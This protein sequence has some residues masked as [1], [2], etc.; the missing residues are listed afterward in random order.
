MEGLNKFKI[1]TVVFI[2]MFIFVVAAI[3]SNTKDASAT[4]N[5][6]KAND[7][8][9]IKKE[10]INDSNISIDN[11]VIEE[12]Y[13]KVEHLSKRV[14]EVAA[15]SSSN[16]ADMKCSIRGIMNNDEIEELSAETALQE[17]R[18]NDSELVMTCRF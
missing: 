4:K 3:Y 18:N 7:K 17:A 15:G 1:L 11:P 14:E 6:D 10:Q 2:A 9:K 8:N 13:I 16:G 5:Q 12:L